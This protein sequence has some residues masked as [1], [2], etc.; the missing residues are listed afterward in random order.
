[1]GFLLKIFTA[2]AAAGFGILGVGTRTRDADGK[3]TK[4]GKTALCGIIVTAILATSAAVYEFAK[5]QKDA[6]AERVKSQ[7]L[8]LAVERGIYPIKGLTSDLIIDIKKDVGVKEYEEMLLHALPPQGSQEPCRQREQYL[9]TDP[10]DGSGRIYTVSATSPL[11]PKTGSVAD[12][13]LQNIFIE[14]AMFKPDHPGAEPNRFSQR[15][16]FGFRLNQTH[17]KATDLHF[18]PSTGALQYDIRDLSIPDELVVDSGFYSLADIS[19]GFVT[20]GSDIAGRYMPITP[21]CE[22]LRI[23]TAQDCLAA[24]MDLEESTEIDTF[25]L[26]FPY[27]KSIAFERNGQSAKCRNAPRDTLVVAVPGTVDE[28]DENGM[29]AFPPEVDLKRY[30]DTFC[31]AIWGSN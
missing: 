25:R 1:L 26:K 19:P 16:S 27:P 28:I 7:H 20:A 29:M 23:T 22:S 5:G 3:L 31:A 6:A 9:C 24:K 21:V 12:V 2:I 17:P 15:K 18:T 13:Y 10:P 8:L 30:T 11:Y 4:N 14:I